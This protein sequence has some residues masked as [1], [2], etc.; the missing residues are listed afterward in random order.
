LK[1]TGRG[2]ASTSYVVLAITFRHGVLQ[3]S[4]GLAL[5]GWVFAA[6]TWMSR[7]VTRRN[8]ALIDD[9]DAT[10]LGHR[11]KSVAL[12]QADKQVIPLYTWVIRL[13]LLVAVISSIVLTVAS[14]WM[15]VS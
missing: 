10:V 6:V 11:E 2:V 4:A 3:W 9:R 15:S 12:R 1:L 8:L 13:S 14:I 7:R 5:A